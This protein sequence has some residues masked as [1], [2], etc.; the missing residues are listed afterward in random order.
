MIFLT[1]LLACQGDKEPNVIIEMPP[2]PEAQEDSAMGWIEGDT[3]LFD[4]GFNEPPVAQLDI[5]QTGSWEL[6]PVAGPYEVL[7]GSMDILE[8]IDGDEVDPW[9]QFTYSI[10]GEITEGGCPTCQLSMTI[11]F[12]VVD[13][14][15]EIEEPMDDEMDGPPERAYTVGDCF[16]PDLP[17]HLEQ[18]QYSYSQIDETIYFNYYSSGIWIPWYEA[19]QVQNQIFFLWQ[20]SIG[21]YGFPDD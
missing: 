12:Y 8:V 13:Y 1:F 4:T 19:S 21:F 7:V 5:T 2:Q 20:N 14:G 10:V 6:S 3:A 11:E 16:A 17:Q 9:C 18:R 15:E